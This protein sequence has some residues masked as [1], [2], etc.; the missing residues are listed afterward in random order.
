M[1]RP[2]GPAKQRG[3]RR[4][5][6]TP[7]ERYEANTSV[8]GTNGYDCERPNGTCYVEKSTAV[9]FLIMG[10]LTSSAPTTKCAAEGNSC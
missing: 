5:R 8:P 6:S 4:P 9:L 1:P 2:T 10:G 7:Q 3:F